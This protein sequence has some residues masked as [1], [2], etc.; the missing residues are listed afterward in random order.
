MFSGEPES[1]PRPVPKGGVFAYGAA[2][3]ITVAAVLSQYVVPRAV[4]SLAP[5][6]SNLV[7]DFLIVY[8]IPILAFLTLVGTQP[9]QGFVASMGKATVEGL[10][11][12]GLLSLTALFVTVLLALAYLIV[13]PSALTRLN[14]PNPDLKA[15]MGD[16]WFWVGFSFVIGITE[17]TI[18]RGWIFGFWT[19]RRSPRWLG[20]A[21]WTSALFVG[22]HLYYARTY[23]AA[24][25]L[26][27]P[28]LFFIGFAFALALRFSGGN[29]LVIGLLHGAYD[30]ASFLSLISMPAGL[31]FRYGLLGVGLMVAGLVYVN[32]NRT[33]RNAGPGPA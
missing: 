28:M 31:A 3:V 23:G 30:S 13:D 8:G 7:G 25:G 32:R 22:V 1:E 16:P 6:Y 4:P 18:F 15:A 27:Y 29:I 26:V 5:I 21:L 12:Y 20:H 17:E 19:A 24:A 33:Y 9:V 11:W 2:V 10:R 14:A